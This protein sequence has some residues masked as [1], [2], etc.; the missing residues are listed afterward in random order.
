MDLDEKSQVVGIWSEYNL[1][2]IVDLVGL[3][4]S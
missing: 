1:M 2:C 3:N 4:Y